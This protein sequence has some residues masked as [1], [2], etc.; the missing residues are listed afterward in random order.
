MQ[1]EFPSEEEHTMS[2]NDG[3]I[4]DPNSKDGRAVIAPEECLKC[5]FKCSIT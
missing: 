5:C 1:P 4:I 3:G 2:I